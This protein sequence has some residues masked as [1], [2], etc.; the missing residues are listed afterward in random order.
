M[1]KE[2]LGVNSS[3]IA[4]MAYD[5]ETEELTFTFNRGGTYTITIPEIEVH[6]WANADSPGLYFN[7]FI[8]GNY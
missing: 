2:S 5:A 6:R 1:A 7:M 4:Y 3:A 8:K